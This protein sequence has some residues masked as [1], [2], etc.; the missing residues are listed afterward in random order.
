VSV[1]YRLAPENPYPAAVDD[2]VEA[3]QWVQRN[4]ESELGVDL[5]RIAVG[6][7]SRQVRF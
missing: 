6:G 4:S 2:A 3:L 5:N 1:D 7:S